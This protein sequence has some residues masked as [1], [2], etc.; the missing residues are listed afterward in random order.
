MPEHP[1]SLKTSCG[2]KAKRWISF[3][4]ISQKRLNSTWNILAGNCSSRALHVGS[5]VVGSGFRGKSLAVFGGQ[6]SEKMNRISK[7]VVLNPPDV[8]IIFLEF[9]KFID[10]G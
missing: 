8:T 2:M 7:T 9:R 4:N 6:V 10:E 3:W 5:R 1:T